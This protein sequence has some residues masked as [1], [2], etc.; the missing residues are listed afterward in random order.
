MVGQ[1]CH[2]GA[3][4][5][6]ARVQGIPV[7]EFEVGGF[8]ATLEHQERRRQPIQAAVQVALACFHIE[9]LRSLENL[10]NLR[11]VSIHFVNRRSDM[12]RGDAEGVEQLFRFS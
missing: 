4:R 5:R 10:N 2:F 7:S 1:M 6:F 12:F 3:G 8:I 11:R 9:E